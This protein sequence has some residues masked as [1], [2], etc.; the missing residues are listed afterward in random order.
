MK[1]LKR[2]EDVKKLLKSSK[3]VIIFFYLEGCPHCE[4]M[5]PICS[6]LEH[7]VPGLEIVKVE[8]GIVP[9]EMGITGFPKFLRIKD[10]KQVSSADGEMTKEELKK[11]LLMSGGRR[12]RNGTRRFRGRGRKVLHRS[13]RRNIP[14]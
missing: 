10:G 8:S 13:T 14:L 3:P 9:A 12:R 2:L 7:E 1:E 6:E 4:A 11:K 5:D